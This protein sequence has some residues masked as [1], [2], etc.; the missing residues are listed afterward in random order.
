[1][2]KEI[3]KKLVKNWFKILQEMIC[4]E[5][6]SLEKG[7]RKFISTKWSKNKKKMKE[8]VNIELLRMV[9]YLKK[10]VLT[11]P[12]YMENFQKNL[13]IKYLELK[14]ILIFGP[15]EFQL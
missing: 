2:N 11:F 12:K 5:I 10:L 13:D 1:M 3:Q 9:K 6:E 4:K 8:V 14:L 15:R 7:K